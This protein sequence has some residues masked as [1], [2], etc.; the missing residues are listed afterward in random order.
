MFQ[1]LKSDLNGNIPVVE[2]DANINDPVFA[3]K[4]IEMML[5]LIGQ[6]K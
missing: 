2:L 4:A 6:R 1:A 3:E 5:E